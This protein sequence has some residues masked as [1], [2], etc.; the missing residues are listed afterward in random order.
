M[1]AQVLDCTRRCRCEPL[2]PGKHDWSA[3]ATRGSPL[4]RQNPPTPSIFRAIAGDL[5]FD[6]PSSIR[7]AAQSGRTQSHSA[8]P[9][10]AMAQRSND[11]MSTP[12]Q[13][14]YAQNA[15]DP[16]ITGPWNGF[17][18]PPPG[19]ARFGSMAG[20]VLP[21]QGGHINDQSHI[22]APAFPT[23]QSPAAA[24]GVIS[25][26][27]P[28]NQPG[29]ALSRTCSEQGSPPHVEQGQAQD[30]IGEAHEEVSM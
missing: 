4:Q 14:N 27:I 28:S 23:E 25:S 6:R 10:D 1:P 18:I 20:R 2:L 7:S 15:L 29:Q 3:T 26:M 30:W 24:T 9:T 13:F 5:Y 22:S 8:A 12:G 17:G 19:Y 21:T 16:L 11:G